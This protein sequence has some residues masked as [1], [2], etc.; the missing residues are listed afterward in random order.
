MPTI[1]VHLS[2]QEFDLLNHF[3]STTNQPLPDLLRTAALANVQNK[4]DTAIYE[5]AYAQYRKNPQL[6]KTE[7]LASQL[8]KGH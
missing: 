6:M 7:T 8:D 4:L 5:T 2:T 3:A 1:P